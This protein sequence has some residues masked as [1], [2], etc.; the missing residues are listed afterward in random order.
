DAGKGANGVFKGHER[1]SCL[2]AFPNVRIFEGIN[3]KQSSARNVA[4][5]GSRGGQGGQAGSTCRRCGARRRGGSDGKC[6]TSS[7]SGETSSIR[8]RQPASSST[9]PAPRSG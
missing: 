1:F 6:R 9:A 4:G 5:R 3:K 7:G 2:R 8:P